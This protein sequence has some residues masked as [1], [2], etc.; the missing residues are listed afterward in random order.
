MERE[1]WRT[2]VLRRPRFFLSGRSG[3]GGGTFRVDASAVMAGAAWTISSLLPARTLLLC[4]PRLRW[5]LESLG[6]VGVEET[7]SRDSCTA[8]YSATG[9]EEAARDL[10]AGA[11]GG[12]RTALPTGAGSDA[13]MKGLAGRAFLLAL[14]A[15]S[16]SRSSLRS[17]CGPYCWA[18]LLTSSVVKLPCLPL[19]DLRPCLRSLAPIVPVA[20]F[21]FLLPEL[22]PLVEGGVVPG[23]LPEARL[24]VVLNC[25]SSTFVSLFC[26]SLSFFDRFSAASTE[27]CSSTP[28]LLLAS[29][30]IFSTS[31]ALAPGSIL[32]EMPRISL[33]RASAFGSLLRFLLF[34]SPSVSFENDTPLPASSSSSSSSSSSASARD[35]VADFQACCCLPRRSRN[36]SLAAPVEREKARVL[37]SSRW[38]WKLP[39]AVSVSAR[40]FMVNDVRP[41][42]LADDSFLPFGLPTTSTSLNRMILRAS[43]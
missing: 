30:K 3:R 18:I 33:R 42:F 29:E 37:L 1:R 40:G 11:G 41:N 20:Y 31:L 16:L 5:E 34:F 23:T 17:I 36:S 25:L 26:F 10:L 7:L 43:S 28:R 35:S 22:P 2:M 6:A 39:S 15:V 9:P 14:L 4:L 38:S 19:L 27:N 24:L 8:L 21:F 13:G 32:V 12:L